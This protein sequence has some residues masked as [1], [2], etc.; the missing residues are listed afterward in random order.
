MIE[1]MYPDELDILLSECARVLKAGGGMRIVVPS[2][3]NAIRAFQEKRHDWFYD[4][5]RVILIHWEVDFPT[6]SSAMDSTGRLS[7]SVISMN[8]SPEPDFWK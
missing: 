2:L 4:A 8:Y 1:H 7:I 6:S 5:F 3:A